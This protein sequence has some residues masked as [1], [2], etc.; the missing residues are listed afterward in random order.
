MAVD[1]LE[2][3]IARVSK[4][5]DAPKVFIEAS[6][7]HLVSSLLGRYFRCSFIPGTPHVGFRP[8]TWFLLSSIPGRTR[9][10]TVS[11]SSTYVYKEVLKNHIVQCGFIDNNADNQPN[12]EENKKKRSDNEIAK[13]HVDD[14]IIEEGSP[15][16]IMDHIDITSKYTGAYAISS[17]EFGSVLS[18]IQNKDY[19][20][21]VSTLL[22][23]L[24][25]GESGTVMLSQRGK[26]KSPDQKRGKRHIPEG[27]YVTMFCGMQE[28]KYYLSPI[29]VG[30]GLMRRIMLLYIKTSDMT[31]ETWKKPLE[32]AREEY[33]EEFR[34]I[35]SDF[36]ERM[37]TY[38]E[39]TQDMHGINLIDTIFVDTEFI[40]NF[41]RKWD[42][43]LI[44]EESYY[45]IYMQGYWEHLTKL[46]MLHAISRNGLDKKTGLLRVDRED[47]RRAND[48][49]TR[50]TKY[51]QEAIEN[52]GY[53][54]DTV[55][56]TV[57]P[58][59][60]VLNI[61]KEYPDGVDQWIL[62]RRLYNIPAKLLGDYLN[63]LIIQERIVRDQR[64]PGSGG[65]R[66]V[67]YKIVE[68]SERK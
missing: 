29:M 68:G 26:D 55:R 37:K 25:Y 31:M 54:E 51:G 61:I 24:Y 22:S 38:Q 46:S 47:C 7:Y 28:P 53:I 23:K 13:E 4:R 50:A 20:K 65:R 21:G 42:E 43:R 64:P 2:N 60:R 8:N 19:Q 5:L 1:L 40:N 11:N 56:S 32:P 62:Y 16:G 39:I 15:E 33:Y 58:Q 66:A 36:N 52:L 41:A 59:M 10:S 44:T 63:D 12:D 30:Q 3:Y 17:S 57:E 9:R 14:T 67:F 6:A 27:L 34:G 45:N 35:I 48:F 18:N 49:L